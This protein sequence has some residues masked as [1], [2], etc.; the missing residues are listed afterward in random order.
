[1]GQQYPSRQIYE[2][3]ADANAN[4]NANANASANATVSRDA[5]VPIAS[6]NARNASPNRLRSLGQVRAMNDSLH[7]ISSSAMTTAYL[8]STAIA[9][10]VRASL[11]T[12]SLLI[13]DSSPHLFCF[14]DYL[15][16]ASDCR[17]LFFIMRLLL[18][19]QR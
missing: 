8:R 11:H 5:S 15:N 4:A 6:S 16:I 2:S 12:D 3:A 10:I 13:I 18:L 1:M 19:F 17:Y 7:R 9:G 14:A